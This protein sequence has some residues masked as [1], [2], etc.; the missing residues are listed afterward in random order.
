MM[1]LTPS[2]NR[3]QLKSEADHKGADY[4]LRII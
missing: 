2:V 1:S 3:V 4:G